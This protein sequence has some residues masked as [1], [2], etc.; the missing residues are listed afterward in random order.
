MPPPLS[1]NRMYN[2][3]LQATNRR[4][5]IVSKAVI[6]CHGEEENPDTIFDLPREDEQEAKRMN[7]SCLRDKH[8]S[9]DHRAGNSNNSNTQH[10]A[11]LPKNH[12]ISGNA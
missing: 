11:I 9:V 7:A 6:Q 4:I 5:I 10:R 1:L 3:D 8:K 2:K 12:V